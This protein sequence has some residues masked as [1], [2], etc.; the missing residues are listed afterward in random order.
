[1]IIDSRETMY[2]YFCNMYGPKALYHNKEYIIYIPDRKINC[3]P[4]NPKPLSFLYK[5]TGHCLVFVILLYIIRCFFQ[6][7]LLLYYVIYFKK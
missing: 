2:L 6:Q 4:S 7:V 5:N 3:A 1:M